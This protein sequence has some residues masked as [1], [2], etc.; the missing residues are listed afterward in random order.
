MI[1]KINNR[2]FMHKNGTYVYNLYISCTLNMV[3]I[4][5]SQTVTSVNFHREK[6]QFLDFESTEAS[7]VLKMMFISFS[8]LETF[9][10]GKLPKVMFSNSLD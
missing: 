8:F 5:F 9:L 6:Y 10:Y 4:V 1:L 2:L 3:I 7:S